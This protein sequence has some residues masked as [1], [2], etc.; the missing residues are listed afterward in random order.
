[1][2]LLLLEKCQVWT[3]PVIL[4]VKLLLM[5]CCDTE[6]E[7]GLELDKCLY[8]GCNPLGHNHNPPHHYPRRLQRRQE[9]PLRESLLH[10]GDPPEGVLRW[11]HPGDV[12]SCRDEDLPAA[13]AVRQ[14]GAN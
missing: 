14:T 8:Y 10:A 11:R 12:L 3:F 5:F 4:L 13:G 9:G 2:K 6:T 7:L 1:M